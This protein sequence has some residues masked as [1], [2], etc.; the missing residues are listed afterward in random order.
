MKI[1]VMGQVVNMFWIEFISDPMF[2]VY[3]LKQVGFDENDKLVFQATLMGDPVLEFQD[4]ATYQGIK[5]FCELV[6]ATM[7]LTNPT[8][9]DPQ[10]N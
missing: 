10:D 3:C 6:G 8:E 7:H 1:N 2:D 4:T 9:V 5:E